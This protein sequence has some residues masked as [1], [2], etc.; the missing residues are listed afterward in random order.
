M[1]DLDFFWNCSYFLSVLPHFVGV[2]S[3]PS[4]V[5]HLRPHVVPGFS[6]HSLGV[7]VED[8]GRAIMMHCFN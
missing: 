1:S 6:V 3:E 2:D 7:G 5:Y 8:G 4:D